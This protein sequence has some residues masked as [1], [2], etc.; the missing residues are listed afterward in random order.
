MTATD[1]L[2]TNY[3]PGDLTAAVRSGK[4]IS[5][6]PA[7]AIVMMAMGTNAANEQADFVISGW[8]DPNLAPGPGFRL[9]DGHFILG[10]KSTGAAKEPIPG[11]GAD[12]WLHADIWAEVT[13]SVANTTPLNTVNRES[14]LLLPTYGFTHLLLEF[15][16]LTTTQVSVAWRPAVMGEVLETF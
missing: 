13:T 16:V 5:I 15:N 9:I 4:M 3:E 8:M 12:T 10:S 2:L 11:W 7:T 14:L 6:H 1:T